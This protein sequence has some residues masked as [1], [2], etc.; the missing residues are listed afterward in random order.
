MGLRDLLLS[1][2]TSFVASAIAT[3]T[4]TIFGYNLVPPEPVSLHLGPI[5]WIQIIVPLGVYLFFLD[6]GRNTLAGIEA[7]AR[8]M[9]RKQRK[10]EKK[11]GRLMNFI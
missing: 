8:A 1:F 10:W 5:F 7:R 11:R 3:Y 9:E 2:V 6:S 4:L